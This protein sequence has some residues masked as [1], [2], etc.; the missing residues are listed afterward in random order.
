MFPV[1]RERIKGFAQ[2][3]LSQKNTNIPPIKIVILDECDSMTKD[4]Q[5]ALR[6]IIEDYSQTTRFCLICNYVSKIIDPIVSRCSAYRFKQLKSELVK[7]KLTEI[8]NLE[9][10]KISD[11]A[12]EKL[13]QIS[14]GDLR[15]SITLLQTASLVTDPNQTIS[16]ETIDEISGFVSQKEI[17]SFF[18]ICRLKSYE[19]V[20][21]KVESIINMGY[22]GIQFLSQL[23]EWI[24][25]SD[26]CLL[27]DQQKSAI[28]ET[29]SVCDKRLMD[30]AHEY[31]QM[32]YVGSS[33]IKA[34]S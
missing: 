12:I 26:E 1:F 11:E 30:G 5:S 24:A 22:S 29:I 14:H 17:E 21:A 28:I 8:S 18:N 16:E 4:A 32:I 2:T 15:H 34:L 3:S 19:K 9:G 23:L 6:R 13:T 25:K 27:N 31:L 7:E 10:C 20:V 33:I